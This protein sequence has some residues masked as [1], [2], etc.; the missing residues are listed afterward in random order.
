MSTTLRLLIVDDN[1][2]LAD[3][4][5]C[6]FTRLGV[7]VTCCGDA[8]TCVRLFSH[9][10]PDVVLVDGKLPGNDGLWLVRQLQTLKPDVPLVMLSGS[11][12]RPFIEAAYAAGIVQFL[13]KPCGLAAVRSAVLQ[14]VKR[15]REQPIQVAESLTDT[16]S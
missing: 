6:G 7:T 4:L 2:D 3:I 13:L 8:E 9:R 10:P 11:D 1:E 12:D 14:A 5:H 15:R 16:L